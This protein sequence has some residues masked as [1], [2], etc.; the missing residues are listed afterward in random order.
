ME[1]ETEILLLPSNKSHCLYCCT[2][3]VFTFSSNILSQP[4]PVQIMNIS[5]IT[6]QYPS[7]LKHAKIVPIFFDGDETDPGNYRPISLLP[8]FNRLFEKVMCHGLKSYLELNE[9]LHN[10][11]YGFRENMSTQPA[12]VDIANSI[13]NKMDNKLFTCDL[14]FDSERAFDTIDHSLLLNKLY[15]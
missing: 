6:G 8:R 9:F 5:V 12:I 10:G 1:L 14:F 2:V 15:H 13:Q 11:Q 3:R 4:L 7:K